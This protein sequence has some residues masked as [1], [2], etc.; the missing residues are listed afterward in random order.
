MSK[1]QTLK[2][3]QIRR[4]SGAQF[5][6]ELNET[7]V[8]NLIEAIERGDHLPP[9]VVFRD[10]DGTL[11]M[12][13]GDHR[14]EARVRKDLREIEADVRN[15]SRDD[16]EFYGAGDNAE[17]GLPRSPKTKRAQVTALLKKWSSM[18]I[19][20]IAN[21]AKVSR[22]FVYQV[23]NDD[24]ELRVTCKRLQVSER[25]YTTKHGTTATMNTAN[26]GRHLQ[27]S[28]TRSDIETPRVGTVG[29]VELDQIKMPW[30]SP[31]FAAQFPIDVLTEAGVV[32][33]GTTEYHGLNGAIQENDEP[34]PTRPL[35]VW[36]RPDADFPQLYSVDV[37]W[38]GSGEKTTTKEPVPFQMLTFQLDSF[39]V[40]IEALKAF[41]WSG[42]KVSII[43][44]KLR[45]VTANGLEMGRALRG[46]QGVL[47]EEQFALWIEAEFQLTI[48]QAYA[49][50]AVVD[51]HSGGTATE[52]EVQNA[53]MEA[54]TALPESVWLQVM[55]DMKNE[56]EVLVA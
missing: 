5:R 52:R 47:S 10:A 26:I 17:H 9:I 33:D 15:G 29:E 12:G 54:F 6:A 25:E 28:S 38:Q 51:L 16:A 43:R 21:H 7:H 1:I 56:S 37:F 48:D 2:I 8:Q 39:G 27:T 14:I 34:D 41:R 18:G 36:L 4:D 44:E 53:V 20:G 24:E 42:I 45:S 49:F 31:A 40:P 11:W 46:G 22:P 3:S 30:E 35:M 50:M 32:F 23:I 13:G 19:S 55:Q